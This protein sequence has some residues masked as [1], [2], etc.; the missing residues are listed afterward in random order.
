M[1]LQPGG[2]HLAQFERQAQQHIAGVGRVVPPRGGEDALQ[3]HVVQP[4]DHGGRKHAGR[5]ARPGQRRYGLQPA[6]WRRR[7]RLHAPRQAGVQSGDGKP[8]PD[9]P[10]CRHALQDVEIAQYAGGFRDDAYRMAEAVQHLQ[11]RARQPQRAVD[12]L[13][14]VGV[15]P[16][17]HRPCDV[18][19]FAQLALEQRGDVGLEHDLRLEIE[20]GRIAEI[21]VAGPGVAVDAAML[22]AAIGIDRAVEADVRAAVPTDGGLAVVPGQCRWQRRQVRQLGADRGPPVVE[23]HRRM[24]VIAHSRVVCRAAA[25]AGKRPLQHIGLRLHRFSLVKRGDGIQVQGASR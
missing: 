13:V 8:N 24:A 20:A 15:G 6:G 12:G 2:E 22:A 5:N 23:G 19:G 3:L 10:T 17:R 7:P 1:L 16:Q 25:V 11:H 9:Q 18:A 4:G 21:G 14:W